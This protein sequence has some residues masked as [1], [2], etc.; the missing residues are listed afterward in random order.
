VTTSTST[1][2][3]IADRNE[4]KFLFALGF[5]GTPTP[6]DN[7]I[8]DFTFIATEELFSARRGYSL[9]ASIPV[10]AFVLS[11]KSVDK[12]IYEHRQKSGGVK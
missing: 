10:L 8:L 7:N 6:R 12:A 4:T 9:N 1:S 3:T 2:I 5:A 11:S